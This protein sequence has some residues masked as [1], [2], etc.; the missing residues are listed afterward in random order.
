MIMPSETENK[1]FISKIVQIGWICSDLVLLEYFL[2]C[3]EELVFFRMM[4]FPKSIIYVVVSVTIFVL[5]N[6]L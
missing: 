2:Y 3:R 4:R 5:V 1:K 6:R